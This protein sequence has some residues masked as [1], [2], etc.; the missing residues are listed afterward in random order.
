[1]VSEAL[2]APDVPGRSPRQDRRSPVPGLVARLLAVAGAGAVWYAGFPPRDL[3]WLAPIA[4][5]VLFAVVSGRTARAGAGYGLVFGLGFFLPLLTWIGEYVDVGVL[6]WVVLAL[7]QAL[8]VGLAGAGIALVS[9]LPAAPL[10]AAALWVAGEALRSRIPFGGFPWGKVAFGQPEG[11]FLPLVSLGG[12]AFLGFA[13]VLC[14][15]GLGGLLRLGA[16][17]LAARRTR[18]GDGTVPAPRSAAPLAR[19]AAPLVALAALP[20]LAG[21]VAGAFAGAAPADGTVTAAVIQGNVP[22]MGL[23]FVSQ[24]RAV[25][26]NHAERTRLLA[27]DVAAGRTAQPDLV[28]WPENASDIDPV[29]NADAYQIIE[30]AVSAVG[31]PTLVGTQE[32]PSVGDLHNTALLWLPGQGP[33]DS[34]R[35][36]EIQP[37]GE[38]MPMRWFVRLF[39]E[40]V[41]RVQREFQPGDE[42][43]SFAMGPASVGVA[44]CWEI[45]FDDRVTSTVGSGAQILAVPSNNAT[46]G[47][48]EMTDQQLAMSRVRAVEH[49]RAVLLPATSGVSAIIMPDGRVV[50]RSEMFT[51]TALVEEVPLRSTTTLAT[52]LGAIPE[53]ALVA[54]ALAALGWVAV[55]GR[56]ARGV[57]PAPESAVAPSSAATARSDA[58]QSDG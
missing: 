55:L 21:G 36:R 50:Q 29:R 26:D 17:H 8:F 34:Y 32:A 2:D 48:T 14:G 35:K 23:D 12:T 54:T 4:F 45:A 15:F 42:A 49:D 13:V 1:M 58:G 56:R 53:W 38:R 46:F 10:W 6:A 27:E 3:W 20:P 57:R 24:R 7:L 18:R 28:V 22:R 37:F 31:A 40:D 51:S 52:R 5:A 43:V 19:R 11:V 16:T 33:V 9:R 47:F 39:S 44:T 41:D 25:L 30:A